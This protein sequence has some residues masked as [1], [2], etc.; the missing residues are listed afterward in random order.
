MFWPLYQ[1]LL[2][3]AGACTL[4]ALVGRRA[5]VPLGL[6][7][8]GLWSILTLQARNI[9]LYRDVADPPIITG[10][11]AWQYTALGLALLCLAATLLYFWGVFPPEDDAAEAVDEAPEQPTAEW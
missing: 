6:L 10:S 9:E 11:I 4:T 8:A 1:T 2:I 3:F 7:S 5:V